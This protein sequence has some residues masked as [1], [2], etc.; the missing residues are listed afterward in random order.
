LVRFNAATIRRAAEP[1]AS[2]PLDGLDGFTAESQSRGLVDTLSGVGPNREHLSIGE[3]LTGHRK[4]TAG[5]SQAGPSLAISVNCFLPSFRGV[6]G[7]GVEGDWQFRQRVLT[8]SE[9]RCAVCGFD[10][11]LGSVSVAL[12][13]AH[14]RWHQ[15]GGPDRESNGLALCV[16]HHKIFDLGAFTLDHQGVMLISDQANGTAGLHEALLRHHGRSGP[17]GA[18]SGSPSRTSSTGTAGRS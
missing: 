18:P 14:I 16:L 15:A 10:V 9:Y 7:Q 17:R 4:L 3:L 13:A 2:S 1:Q 12:D 6:A 5:A 11:R 8:A